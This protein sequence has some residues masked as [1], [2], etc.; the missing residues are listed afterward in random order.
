MLGEA[1]LM[2]KEN[3]DKFF[4]SWKEVKKINLTTP[5]FFDARTV[6]KF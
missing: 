2:L 6:H 3:A 4:Y 1:N 5:W